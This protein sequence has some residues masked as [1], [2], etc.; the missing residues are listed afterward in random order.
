MSTFDTHKALVKTEPWRAL[1]VRGDLIIKYEHFN[2]IE[3][4]LIKVS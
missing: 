4:F 2:Q 1:C 3:F